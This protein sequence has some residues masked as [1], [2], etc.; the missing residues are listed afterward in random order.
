MNSYHKRIATCYFLV[1]ALMFVCILR[2]FSIALDP[3]YKTVAETA[4]SRKIPIGYSRGTVYDAYGTPLTNAKIVYCN[5]IMDKPTALIAL[6]DLFS[7]DEIEEVT[8]EIRNEGF[9]VRYTEEKLTA[10][11]IYSYAVTEQVSGDT[12]ATHL[13]GYTDYKGKGV[14]GLEQSFDSLL[15]SEKENF[16][17]FTLSGR[18]EMLEGIEPTFSYDYKTEKNGVRTTLD[19]KLQAIAEN[20][21]ETIDEGAVVITEIASGKI[22][23]LVS[24]PGFSPLSVA[25]ALSDEA[26]PLLNRAL[27]TYNVGSVFKPYVAAAG[28]EKNLYYY[29][30]CKGYTDIDGLTF[31][32]HNLGGHGEVDMTAALKYSCNSFFYEFIQ[33]VGGGAVIDIARKAGFDSSITLADGLVCK[34]GS[35]GSTAVYSLSRR[36]LANL[37]IGQG[38]L[39]LSP[40]AIT[41]LYMA[42]AGGGRYRTP[43][44]IEGEIKDGVFTS[45]PLPAEITVMNET[46]AARLKN[47]LS[48]VLT[49]GGTGAAAAPTLTTAAGKTGTAQTGIIRQGKKVTNS[50]FCGFFPLDEPKYA[51]TLL[52]VNADRPCSSIFAAIADEITAAEKK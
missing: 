20:N 4:A 37:S 12:L 9:A 2:L 49:E 39:M 21:A 50:W 26:Q 27:C 17:S 43:S 15:S 48:G 13:I 52:S 32:C 18:G 29:T 1:V 24:R 47:D 30:N 46:T 36:S 6:Y 34:A 23:A 22:R 16:I 5:L 7:S 51:V 31:S 42:I 45:R 8:E 44:L 10:E 40:L 28:Y 11:G 41:N 3:E 33:S 38:E 35:L 19:A 25:E 14:C